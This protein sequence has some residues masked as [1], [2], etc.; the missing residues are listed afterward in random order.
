MNVFVV[1]MVAVLGTM[2]LAGLY[3]RS[4]YIDDAWLG[5]R[6]YWLAR[7]GVARSELFVG[8]IP[9]MSSNSWSMT[10]AW[11]MQRLVRPL[12]IAKV[13]AAPMRNSPRTA[14]RRSILDAPRSDACCE[15]G[16][17]W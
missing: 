5:E 10:A 2:A 4:C 12:R 14:T 15:R 17:R 3:H 8:G 1:A 13:S 11:P 16:G 7:E 6:A 9:P